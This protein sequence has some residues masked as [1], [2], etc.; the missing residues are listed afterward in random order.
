[1]D[2]FD[3]SQLAQVLGL[4]LPMAREGL[5]M[6]GAVPW[7]VRVPLLL[8]LL[9]I[10]YLAV[11]NL[12]RV[13]MAGKLGRVALIL[14]V[15]ALVVGFVLDLLANLVIFTVLLGELPRWGEWTVTARLKRHLATSS[16]YRLAVA[17]WFETELL[18]EFD[19][20]GYHAGPGEVD[21][22]A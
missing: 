20:K 2:G 8:W 12:Q 17:H 21:I 7:A 6:L 18:A 10:F 11:M 14:G 13:H 1:M 9:W 15:P 16:G 5:S 19:H 3:F 22:H 4:F